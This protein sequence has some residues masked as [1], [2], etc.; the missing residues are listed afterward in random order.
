MSSKPRGDR[1][2][3]ANIQIARLSE[4]MRTLGS[5]MVKPGRP[6]AMACAA[7]FTAGSLARSFAIP[8]ADWWASGKPSNW[9]L[10][11][12]GLVT[13]I[14]GVLNLRSARE[15]KRDKELAEGT[16]LVAAHVHD[17]C[18]EIPLTDIEVIVWVVA[19][20]PF[21]RYLA[22][23]QDFV[24][25]ERMANSGVTWVRDKGDRELLAPRGSDLHQSGE[26]LLRADSQPSGVRGAPPER[27]IPPD[28]AGANQHAPLRR[29]L[30]GSAEGEASRHWDLL[31][32]PTCLDR[33]AWRGPPG[34]AGRCAD[35]DEVVPGDGAEAQS[36]HDSAQV[37]EC[38]P[39]F[40]VALR[41]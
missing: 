17:E 19:G 5:L 11:A 36:Q 34:S 15:H 7:L 13:G 3:K 12:V 18:R 26:G 14:A 25:G 32:W 23:A 38:P 4:R 16:R 8:D 2:V 37:S 29:R 9:A 10:V 24:L 28:M 20:V 22:K 21:G 27:Q 30:G 31:C 35:G 41:P 40:R 33:R 39:W 6:L 1:A